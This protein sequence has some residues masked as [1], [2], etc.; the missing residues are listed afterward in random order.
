MLALKS[1]FS[2]EINFFS[3]RNKG[4]VGKTYFAVAVSKKSGSITFDNLKGL[5]TCH[6]GYA[7]TAGW[8]MP[9]GNLVEKSLFIK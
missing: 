7:K 2:F 6:T 1:D 5:K 4:E 3:D 8:M 9:V